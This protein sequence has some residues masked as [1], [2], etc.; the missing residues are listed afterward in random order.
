MKIYLKYIIDNK[1]RCSKNK[2][3]SIRLLMEKSNVG[4]LMDDDVE[5]KCNWLEE[6]TSTIKN[7]IIHPW[8]TVKCLR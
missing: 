7:G 1:W 5:Y 4:F 6:Y 3:T 2:N 8:V